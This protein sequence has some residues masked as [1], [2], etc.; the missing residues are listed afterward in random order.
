[1]TAVLIDELAVPTLDLAT[2]AWLVFD[3]D[4][5]VGYACAVGNGD[6]RLVDTEVVAPD[7]TGCA[8]PSSSTSA[9]FN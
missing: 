7:P 6:R 9:A 2:D 8:P 1:M 4:T 3:G 5:P